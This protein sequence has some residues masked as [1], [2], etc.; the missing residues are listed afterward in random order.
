M[1]IFPAI[2]SV[3][4]ILTSVPQ[5]VQS[6]GYC[7]QKQFIP[8]YRSLKSVSKIP[9]VPVQWKH[10]SVCMRLQSS[11]SDT[12]D[13]DDDGNQSES[14]EELCMKQAESYFAE[15]DYAATDPN[16]SWVTVKRNKPPREQLIKFASEE[17]RRWRVIKYYEIMTLISVGFF[18]LN[19]SVFINSHHK[20]YTVLHEPIEKVIVACGEALLILLSRILRGAVVVRFLLLS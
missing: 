16:T 1:M 7:P 17:W 18:L 5:S 19:P 13:Q 11:S 3:Y 9:N 14:D 20:Y 8:C 10:D 4:F 15:V 2:L 12:V 6:F